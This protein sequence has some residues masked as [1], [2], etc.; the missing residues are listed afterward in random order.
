MAIVSGVA[1]VAAAGTPVQLSATPLMADWV[2]LHRSNTANTGN[3]VWGGSNTLLSTN[4]GIPIGNGSAFAMKI[5]G[6]I[7]LSEIYVDAANNGDRC[8]FVYKTATR[9]L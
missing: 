7:D 3:I 1:T 2:M 4:M 9:I 5:D 6:P 8:S